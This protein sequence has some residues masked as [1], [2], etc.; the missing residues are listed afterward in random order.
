[1][2]RCDRI[3]LVIC[4]IGL[5]S[6]GELFIATQAFAEKRVALVI[7][8]LVYSHAPELRN[9]GNDA[10]AIGTLLKNIGFDVVKLHENLGVNDM[11]G[12]LRDFY[13][14]VRGADI[15]VVF[16]AGHG[17]EVNG[18]NY[19]FAKW[20]SLNHPQIPHRFHLQH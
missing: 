4:L 15:A 14:N 6:F 1:M 16:Y 12:V 9:P 19:L 17:I 11:R 20:P 7:G 18:N 10:T 8:N 13:S 2:A 3:P 5:I